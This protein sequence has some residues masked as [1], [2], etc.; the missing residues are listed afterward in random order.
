M[1]FVKIELNHIGKI[2]EYKTELDLEVGKT[3][4][5]VRANGWAPPMRAK[6]I[7]ISDTPEYSGIITEILQVTEEEGF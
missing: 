1:K 5:I 2:Y 4:R 3:Y 7:N 6:V